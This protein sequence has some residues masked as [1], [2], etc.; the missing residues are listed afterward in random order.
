MRVYCERVGATFHVD[1][2]RSCPECGS[3]VHSEYFR[4]DCG[5]Y[6]NATKSNGSAGADF[7][8]G[9]STL[10]GR[11]CVLPNGHDGQCS[12]S[13]FEVFAGIHDS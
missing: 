11:H 13:V 6:V 4:D 7:A 2:D 8:D 10:F 9:P 12:A 1:L 3:K 5:C